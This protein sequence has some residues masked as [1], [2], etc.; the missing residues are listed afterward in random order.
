M[1]Y[2][3]SLL[4][5]VEILAYLGLWPAFVSE[6]PWTL[7]TSAFVHFEWWHLF[8]NMLLLFFFG[9]HLIWL[10]GEGMF[11]LLYFGGGL[12]GSVFYVLLGEP[13]VPVVGASGAAFALAGALVVFAPRAK[14]IILP[15]PIPMPLWVWVVLSITIFSFLPGIAW[16]AH[17]GGLIFGLLLGSGRLLTARRRLRYRSPG[18]RA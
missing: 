5:Y 3:T 11:L 4:F 1:V 13:L 6:M 7:L 14:I 18:A 8:G 9:R 12:L 10:L 17:L 2:L 16:Q 15:I